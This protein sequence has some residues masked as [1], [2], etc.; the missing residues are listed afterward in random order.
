MTAI[1]SPGTAENVRSDRTDRV[2]RT[3]HVELPIEKVAMCKDKGARTP[4]INAGWGL[5]KVH[6]ILVT[7]PAWRWN[8]THG[9]G[10]EGVTTSALL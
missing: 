9:P 8:Q 5:E 3:G 7:P 10:R 4:G 6:P 1:S 2:C